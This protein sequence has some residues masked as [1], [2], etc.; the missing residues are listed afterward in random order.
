MNKVTRHLRHD[1]NT[2][3]SHFYRSVNS[4]SELNY[5]PNIDQKITKRKF[6]S[7]AIPTISAE[8]FTN[9]LSEPHRVSIITEC[10]R[11]R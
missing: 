5:H 10:D 11:Q 1:Q 8:N 3:H 9:I 6:E 7:I 2:K 4:Q